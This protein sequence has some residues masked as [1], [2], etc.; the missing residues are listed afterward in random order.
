[1]RMHLGFAASRLA[2][3]SALSAA[4]L[5]LAPVALADSAF[6]GLNGSW[7]GSGIIKYTDG[8]TENMRCNARYS[9]GDSDM[10]MAINCS[11]SARNI[12]VSGKL[13][14]AGGRVSGS[15]AESNMGVEGSASGKASPGR[16][17]LGLGGGLSGSMSV[18]Y[19][20]GHQSVAISVD[21]VSLKSVS[22]NL[23]K[24]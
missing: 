18:S 22:M 17:S 2:S 20:G 19:T 24:R 4:M 13:H 12:G 1:M 16:L 11:S 10:S 23:N 21:N 6:N 3:L 8:S 14:N 5:A 7:G 9:G 15:W